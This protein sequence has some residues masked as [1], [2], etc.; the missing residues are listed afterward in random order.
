MTRQKVVLQRSVSALI[1]R[2]DAHHPGPITTLPQKARVRMSGRCLE[3]GMLEIEWRG[4]RF[5][6][7]AV[8]LEERGIPARTDGGA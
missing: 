7:F 3:P 6:V 5:L 2:A 4:S 8:D 1:F